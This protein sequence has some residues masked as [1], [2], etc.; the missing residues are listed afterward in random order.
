MTSIVHDFYDDLRRSQKLSDEPSWV[1]F[2]RRIW[3]DMLSCVRLDAD[4][5]LQRA[6]VDRAVFLPRRQLPIYIDEKNRPPREDGKPSWDDFLLEEWSNLGRKKVGWTLD[7]TKVCD[8]VA[9]AI[10]DR[11]KCY[12]LPFEPLRIACVSHL[13]EWKR[14][15]GAYPK[16]TQNHGYTTRNC[17]V[18]WDDLWRAIRRV[19]MRRWGSDLRLPTATEASGQLVMEWGRKE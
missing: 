12:L 7:E 9:Y 4:S 10:H 17:V 11:H 14:R 13:D 8:F 5:E 2:Y 1:E 18:Q 15:K 16:D 3:P 19:S 6:G